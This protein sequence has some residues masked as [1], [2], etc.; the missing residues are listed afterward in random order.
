MLRVL[1]TVN[2]EPLKIELR[3]T[4]VSFSAFNQFE[5]EL[6]DVDSVLYTD[7]I[8]EALI[9]IDGES[10]LRDRIHDIPNDALVSE[11]MD[12][13]NALL[14]QVE[15][16]AQRRPAVPVFLSNIALP[17]RTCCT[18]LNS[19]QTPSFHNL[20]YM[21][22]NAITG[23]SS[24]CSNVSVL[25]W[26]GIVMERGI[27]TLIE[28]KFWYLARVR[29][30]KEGLIAL[31]REYKR[32][33][34][35]VRRGPKKVL[36]LDLDNTLWG[37]VLGDLG[38]SGIEIGEDGVGKAYREFQAAIKGLKKTG[39]LLGIVSKNDLED[40]NDTLRRHSM[41]CLRPEDFAAIRVNWL[42]KPENII[43]IADELN[44]GIDSIVFVDDNAMERDLVRSALPDVA[45]PDFPADVT[46]LRRWLLSTVAP[47]YFGRLHLSSEDLKKTEQ[48][49]A[50]ASRRELAAQMTVAEY[51]K[52]LGMRVTV[53]EQAMEFRARVAQ[54]IQK[55]NQFNL[56]NRRHTPGEIDAMCA[57]EAH[58]VF[59]LDYEDKFGKEGIIAAAI[60]ICGGETA[61]IDE[62]VMSCRVIGRT[63]EYMFLRSMVESLH[64]SGVRI[65]E[66]HY[67]PTPRNG[68]AADFYCKAGL[69]RCSE[70]L[71]RGR[72]EDILRNLGSMIA[73]YEVCVA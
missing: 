26:L 45:V 10:L 66:G 34:R 62:F 23:L 16:F 29:L 4:P 43:S 13:V 1:S 19:N 39:V 52:C 12:E 70:V 5:R 71:Y 24:R 9:F 25:D 46:Q 72:T 32:L 2:L 58:R 55:T 51:L 21:V 63:V 42:P 41:M 22:N 7:D 54:L 17:P 40:V 38:I 14:K 65:L 60:A 11:V 35:T 56:T 53:H 37:G 20:G 68:V 28:H 8:T 44:V 59:A 6:V 48:Y 47:D 33:Q 61:S 69:E 57:S 50:N 31:A 73:K 49:R 15:A 67:T 18:F 3:P 64:A 30:T 27:E 36:L